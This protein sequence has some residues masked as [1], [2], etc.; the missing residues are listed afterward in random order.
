MVTRMRK[1]C[2]HCGKTFEGRRCPC[3]PRPKRRP[4]PGDATRSQREPWRSEYGE[5]EYQ[6]NRQL[7]MAR[8]NGRCKYCHGQCAVFDGRRWIT[9]GMGGEVHHK[10]PLCE[11]GTNDS[12]NLELVCIPCHRAL[13]AA[14]RNARDA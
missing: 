7:A 9:R 1:Y 6:R 13:D 12:T 4:T 2:P 5:V 10:V 11:G 3:R 8:T 14:R